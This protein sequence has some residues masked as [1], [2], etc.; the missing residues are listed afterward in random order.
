MSWKNNLGALAVAL[1]LSFVGHAGMNFYD[2]K[3][4]YD[5]LEYEGD[6]FE[7]YKAKFEVEHNF[8]KDNVYTLTVSG[9]DDSYMRFVDTDKEDL[10]MEEMYI[11][12]PNAPIKSLVRSEL[13]KNANKDDLILFFEVQSLVRNY[14]E[15]LWNKK[16]G[17]LSPEPSKKS[18]QKK[19]KS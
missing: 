3:T 5:F 10:I 11:K 16:K 17:V 8:F 15:Q 2:R 18:K 6:F 9:D 7:G 4:K 13:I 14:I 19:T 12:P 1:S